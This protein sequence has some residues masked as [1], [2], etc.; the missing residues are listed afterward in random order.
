MKNLHRKKTYVNNKL[1]IYNYTFSSIRN[2][3]N[4][5]YHYKIFILM[6]YVS[7]ESQVSTKTHVMSFNGQ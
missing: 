2:I 6:E 5:E 7:Y 4:L 3:K 1:Q